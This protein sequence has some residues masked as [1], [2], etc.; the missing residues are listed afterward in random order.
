MAETAG[1]VAAQRFT[2]DTLMG[3]FGTPLTTTLNSFD[4]AVATT[5]LV[6]AKWY[7]FISTQDCHILF[8]ASGSATTSDMF[9][10]AGIPEIFYLGAGLTRVSVIKKRTAGILYITQ[11]QTNPKA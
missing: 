2:E 7:R 5:G 10:K 9:L 4:A 11:M 1:P 6:T 3:V 8:A